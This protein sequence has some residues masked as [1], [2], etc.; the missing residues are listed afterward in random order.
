MSAESVREP[1]NEDPQVSPV[2][3]SEPLAID[4]QGVSRG[5]G[6]SASSDA[7]QGRDLK[8]EDADGTE[9]RSTSKDEALLTTEEPRAETE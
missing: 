6:N 8:V 4:A 1:Q 3:E 2:T 9:P 5:P 7:V